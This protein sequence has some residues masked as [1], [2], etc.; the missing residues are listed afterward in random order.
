MQSSGA[1]PISWLL[2][3]TAS[4]LVS[5]GLSAQ[6]QSYYGYVTADSPEPESLETTATPNPSD[7]VASSAPVGNALGKAMLKSLN[8]PQSSSPAPVEPTAPAVAQQ[9]AVNSL[10]ILRRS[11]V[12]MGGNIGLSGEETEPTEPTAPAVAQL[13]GVN[14][15]GILR[16]SYIGVGGNIGLSGEETQL[17]E[18]AAVIFSKLGFT[19]NFSLRNS[20]SF[21][22]ETVTTVALTADFPIGNP[23][24]G[25]AVVIPFAGGGVL[26][27][28]DNDWEADPL[29]SGGVDIPIPPK[30]TGTARV[31]VVFA[32]DDEVDVGLVLGVGYNFKLF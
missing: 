31:N 32:D 26:L 16:R 27:K 18:E 30:F 7:S 1:K 20:V 12:G 15:L 14:P 3:L 28:P 2:T 21:G 8:L 9:P 11:Y 22:D 25:Q 6:A 24:T 19:E 4:I 17:S 5:S 10:G 23:L 13:P 29:V